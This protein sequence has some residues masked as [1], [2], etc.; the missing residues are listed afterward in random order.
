MSL[1]GV[2]LTPVNTSLDLDRSKLYGIRQAAPC[3]EPRPPTP[4]DSGPEVIDLLAEN[5][6]LKLAARLSSVNHGEEIVPILVEEPH[7]PQ[8]V[9]RV[10]FTPQP[11]DEV[12][13]NAIVFDY[14]A[15]MT[16]LQEQVRERQIFALKVANLLCEDP[17]PKKKP[18]QR[19]APRVNCFERRPPKQPRPTL[20]PKIKASERPE[21]VRRRPDPE[22]QMLGDSL[23]IRRVAVAT[24]NQRRPATT[25][26]VHKKF[27]SAAPPQRPPRSAQ[28]RYRSPP[29]RQPRV[30]QLGLADYGDLAKSVV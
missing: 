8:T 2:R 30:V 4:P 9:R 3:S 19:R 18:A 6:K 12:P 25:R 26:P 21:P 10:H 20:P 14:R 23:M 22:D 17:P 15:A 13:R 11:G 27:E 16:D 29:P 24:G 5:Y 1:T 7:E 28:R